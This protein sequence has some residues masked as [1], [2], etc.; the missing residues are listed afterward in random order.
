MDR[1]S[2]LSENGEI[3]NFDQKLR[4]SSSETEFGQNP[5]MLEVWDMDT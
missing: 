1:V 2:T 4:K 5:S 3:V